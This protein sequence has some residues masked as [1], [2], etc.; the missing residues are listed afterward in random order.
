[1]N[2]MNIS[3]ADSRVLKQVIKSALNTKSETERY[4]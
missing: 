4:I 3:T 1:M 2:A